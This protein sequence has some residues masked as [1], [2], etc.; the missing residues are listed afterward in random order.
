MIASKYPLLDI[1]PPKFIAAHRGGGSSFGP[2]NSIYTF[3]KSVD[4]VKVAVLEIDVRTTLDGVLVLSHDDKQY[5]GKISGM[6]YAEIVSYDAAANWCPNGDGVYPLRGKGY[7]VPRFEDV[8]DRFKEH[9]NLIIYIDLKSAGIIGDVLSM[10]KERGLMD[11]IILGA[12]DPVTNNE[13]VSV[14]PDYVPSTVSWSQVLKLLFL[15]KIGKADNFVKSLPHPIVGFPMGHFAG[16]GMVPKDIVNYIH[17]HG[18]KVWV[19]GPEL[20]NPDFMSYAWSCGVDAIFT[21]RPDLGVKTL[22]NMVFQ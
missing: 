10:V 17:S 20:D 5:F 12:V 9:P 15:W 8:L 19:F 1:L 13:M 7:S 14:K 3:E 22:D 21:D 16:K 6:T 18:K 2:E 4:E 11:R